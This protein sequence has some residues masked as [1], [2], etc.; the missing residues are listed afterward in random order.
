MMFGSIVYTNRNAIAEL[1]NGN[2]DA[3]LALMRAALTTLKEQGGEIALS[4]SSPS[5]RGKNSFL[6]AAAQP[7]TSVPVLTCD[8]EE[9]AEAILLGSFTRAFDLDEIAL[10]SCIKNANTV[11]CLCAAA[12][13][14]NMALSL[15]L[16]GLRQTGR[17]LSLQ[18]AAKCYEKAFSIL[19]SIPQEDQ[20]GE[21][22]SSSLMLA[23]VLNLIA[24]QQAVTA[25][26]SAANGVSPS[27]QSWKKLYL[28]LFDWTVSTGVVASLADATEFEFFTTSA[29]LFNNEHLIAAPAA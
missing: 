25:T 8:E 13:L 19:A 21:S 14:Y 2:Y 9:A 10:A 28:E 22:V 6:H 5:A 18:R 7:L 11:T 1:R 12:C 24:C 16:Q 29:L 17:A 4:P 3:C 23:S 20:R 26:G 27:L 15:H